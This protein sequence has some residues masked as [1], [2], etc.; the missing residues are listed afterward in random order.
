MGAATCVAVRDTPR[1]ALE[2]FAQRR[3]IRSS[4]EDQTLEP[5]T[6]APLRI[7]VGAYDRISTLEEVYANPVAGAETRV[8]PDASH[9][10]PWTAPEEVAQQA[11]LSL[12]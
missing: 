9:D 8:V 10:L 4:Y 7:L 5:E 3:A 2:A 12:P 6:S 11:R 1:V